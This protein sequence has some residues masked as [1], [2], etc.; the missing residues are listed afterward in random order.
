ML[1]IRRSTTD[2]I[3]ETLAEIPVSTQLQILNLIKPIA[4]EEPEPKHINKII[5]S[6]YQSAK[7]QKGLHNF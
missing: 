3:I 5:R 7:F 2:R 6:F 1:R 4:I